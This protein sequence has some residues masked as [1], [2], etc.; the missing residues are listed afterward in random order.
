M[1]A[2]QSGLQ[3]GSLVSGGT[4]PTSSSG[5]CEVRRQANPFSLLTMGL[6]T[7][8]DSGKLPDPGHCLIALAS[9][10]V[11]HWRFVSFPSQALSPR[12]THPIQE[13]CVV[14]RADAVAVGED[15]EVRVVSPD[16]L[17]VTKVVVCLEEDGRVLDWVAG[18]ADVSVG[19][20]LHDAANL[21]VGQVMWEK[22]S[23][24]SRSLEARPQDGKKTPS[25]TEPQP[26]GFDV[27]LGRYG[28]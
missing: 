6:K 17:A 14:G 26:P 16:L 4:R 2:V 7:G 27:E 18:R 5:I 21:W 19:P 8:H 20:G 24:E 22:W 9:R 10:S 11:G 1:S 13:V 3:P 15:E 28:V 12:M 25:E 23:A